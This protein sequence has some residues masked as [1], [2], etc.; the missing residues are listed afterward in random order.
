MIARKDEAQ[1]GLCA[2]LELRA[3]VQDSEMTQ[4]QQHRPDSE[5]KISIIEELT[6]TPDVNPTN[7]GVSVNHG[8][9][10][11]SGEVESYPE[12]LQAERAAMRV[13]GVT[14]IAQEITVRTNYGNVNDTDIAREATN[15][16]ENSV[17]L[18]AG[19]VKVKV[20][21]NVVTLSGSVPWNYQRESASRAVRHL[22]GVHDVFNIMTI[23]PTASSTGI[24]A[25]IAAALVRSATLDAQHTKVT[26][27]EKGNVT[28]EGSVQS[29]AERHHAERVAWA[30]PGVTSVLNKMLIT[31]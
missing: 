2:L 25:S 15:A 5:L 23:K 20:H 9:V 30:A 18:P 27:D 16:I 11:L 29:W 28:L 21:D 4:T 17:N 1:L 7:I 12:K 8:A 24:K 3:I 6:W 10:T 22:K 31:N 13:R 26:A 19:S 14:G